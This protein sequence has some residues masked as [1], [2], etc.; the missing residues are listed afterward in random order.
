LI[1]PRS[2][3]RLVM[4]LATLLLVIGCSATPTATAL[5]T[6]SADADVS[7]ELF[8][9]TVV[10]VPGVPQPAAT[11]API[12][13]PVPGVPQPAATA[14]PALVPGVGNLMRPAGAPIQSFRVLASYPHDPEAFTQ[15]LVY[16][17]DDSFY[18]STGLYE[19][20]SLRE[21]DLATGEVRRSVLLNQIAPP[22]AGA[23]PH[24]AEGIAVFGEQIFQL[25]WQ[26]GFG[27]IYDRASFTEQGR[28]SYPPPGR[29]LPVEGWG[30]TDDGTRLI[31]S[32]GTA[33]L[34]FVDPAATSA[35]GVLSV[36]DQIAVYDEF[37]SVTWLNELEYINGEI[38][39]NLWKSD[40]IARIDPAT[41]EVRAYIDLS[42]LRALLPP[43]GNPEV[44]NGIAYD[45]ASD[46]LFVTGKWWP[47]LFEIR[48]EP[49]LL[50]GLY[51]PYLEIG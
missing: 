19:R 35:S 27:L 17:T 39:A 33:N 51:L 22:A 6:A 14:P 42:E 4:L 44:L 29:A 31:M 32:D 43:G 8:V 1:L 24:F 47:T 11:T 23:E 41:G 49:L 3:H 15:G 12:V 38:Y 21:V 34:Y 13:V 2:L 16:L 50:H 26:S 45:T 20:S 25:T 48:L 36:L 37:G 9:T 30:L 7:R 28:F 18:E 5:P 10:P 46:R 40:L